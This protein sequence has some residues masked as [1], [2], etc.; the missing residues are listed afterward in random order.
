MFY[1]NTE[2]VL[3]SGVLYTT[4]G[5]HRTMASV[6]ERRSYRDRDTKCFGEFLIK[7]LETKGLGEYRT[8]PGTHDRGLL[9]S[10]SLL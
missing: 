7:P 5:F 8:G 3:S 10:L 2:V 9:Q 4:G 1:R 6:K